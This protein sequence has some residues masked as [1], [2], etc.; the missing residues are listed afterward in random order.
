[1]SALIQQTTQM[2]SLLPEE[3]VSIINA[4]VKKLL[5]A[6]DPD[7]T[8]VTADEKKALDI[9][10]KELNAGEYVTEDEIWS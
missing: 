8:K 9:A 1:M 5:L 4:L 10:E 7:F 6:W 3:D 2:L